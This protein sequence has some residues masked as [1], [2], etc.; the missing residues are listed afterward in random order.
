[1]S[2]SSITTASVSVTVAKEGRNLTECGE[3]E[4]RTNEECKGACLVGVRKEGLKVNPIENGGI[5]GCNGRW[6]SGDSACIF[7]FCSLFW[8]R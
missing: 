1:V 5:R 7:I 3:R 6:R 8:Q 4:N 2:P